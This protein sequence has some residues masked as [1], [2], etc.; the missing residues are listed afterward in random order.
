MLSHF[1]DEEHILVGVVVF[2]YVYVYVYYRDTMLKYC[3]FVC[4]V[5]VIVVIII[6]VNDDFRCRSS[7]T[8]MYL[9][10]KIG[11]RGYPDYVY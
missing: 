7:V 11:E 8:R 6:G 4:I 10:T 9:Q 1:L 5:F 2:V 3:Y